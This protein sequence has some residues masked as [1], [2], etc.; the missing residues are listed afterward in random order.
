M[1]PLVS[2]IIPSYNHRKYILKLLESIN[3]QTYPTIEV[4]IVDDG[5]TDG[6]VEYLESVKEKYNFKLISKKNEGLCATINRGLD[7]VR[8]EYI[9]II[10]S[11]DFMPATR[12]SEQIE[13]ISNSPFDAI[14][15]GMTVVSE[16]SVTLNYVKPL[17]IGE[18]FFDEMLYKNLICAPTVMFRA[19]TFTKFGRY[20]PNHLI[21]DYSM[22]LRIL[23][24]KGRIAN[25][26]HNWAFYR[27]NPLVNRKK[28]EWYYKGLKQV[29]A[30]YENMPVAAKALA[31]NKF[32][33]LLKVAIFDGFLE[34]QKAVYDE[35]LSLSSVSLVPV[36]LISLLPLFIRRVLSKRINKT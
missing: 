26:N 23:S 5:S 3:E 22:W 2:I 25:F 15:G 7:E 27:V 28:I 6:S 20:N 32:K 18:V 35:K 13:K 24:Q 33:Y 10:A 12:L 21:E 34:L 36:Y 11:D 29:F 9:V 31:R 14:G 8:G 19:E 4:I 1:S 30:E 16:N 17:K